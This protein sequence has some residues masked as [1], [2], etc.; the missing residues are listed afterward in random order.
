PTPEGVIHPVNGVSFDVRRGEAVCIVG[1]S[2]SGKSMTALTLMALLPQHAVRRAAS[3]RFNGEEL[4]DDLPGRIGALRGN[5]IAMIFQDPMTALDPVQTVGG[6]LT[7]VYRSH[8][9]TTYAAALE[10]AL[11]LLQKV[12]IN[13][14]KRRLGQYP[15]E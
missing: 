2:G 10:R 5:R 1:E 7:E 13:N 14:P 15:H 4:K 12:G 3:L 6:Q 8:N 9:R 11:F